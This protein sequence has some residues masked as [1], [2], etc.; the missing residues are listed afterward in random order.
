MILSRDA[1]P[2]H[3]GQMLQIADRFNIPASQ[4]IDFSANINPDG[5]P[6]AV[7]S[8]LRACLEDT[9]MLTTYPNLEETALKQSIAEYC[10]ISPR[11]IVVANGFVQLLECALRVLKVKRCLLPVPAFVEYGRSL[12][13]VGVEVGTNHLKSGHNFGYDIDVLLNGDHDAILLANPQNPSGILT[14]KAFLCELVSRC[15]AK[16]ISV[17]LDEAFIDYSPFDSLTPIAHQYANLIVFRSVTKFHG[18]PGLRVAYA[19]A[20]GGIAQALHEN[21]PPWPIT[22]LASRAVAAAL[23]DHL[24]N[25]EGRTRNERRRELL[26]NGFCA[27]GIESFPGAANFLLIRLPADISAELF[28]RRMIVDHHIVLRDCSNYENLPAGF[29][30]VAVRTEQENARLL[31]AISLTLPTAMRTLE[32]V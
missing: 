21:L 25:E 5:P 11:N 7:M 32:S 29:L 1:V 18:I 28:W 14:S 26:R 27:L 15:A 17:F 9:S 24:F 30:R 10:G 19:T 20:S 8:S 4:L 6:A 22:T 3:G 12:T 16:K 2:L 23:Q 13:R 31:H